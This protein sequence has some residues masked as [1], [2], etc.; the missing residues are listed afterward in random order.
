MSIFF[1][2]IFLF[3]FMHSDKMWTSQVSTCE[4]TLLYV[5]AR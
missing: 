5:V 2:H 1:Q 4:L 3:Y